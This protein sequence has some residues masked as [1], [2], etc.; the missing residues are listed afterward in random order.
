M[1]RAI[2]HAARDQPVFQHPALAVDVVQ[3]QIE[4]RDTLLET[5]FEARPVGRGDDPRHV[6]EQKEGEE[7]DEDRKQEEVRGTF[8]I[9]EPAVA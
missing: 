2:D 9:L 5:R 1:L 6:P 7:R 4:R 8:A 3:K